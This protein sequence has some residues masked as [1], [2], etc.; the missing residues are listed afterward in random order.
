MER[1][2]KPGEVWEDATLIPKTPAL[3]DARVREPD[4]VPAEAPEVVEEKV[5]AEA[6][7]NNLMDQNT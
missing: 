5:A 4:K 3:E 2:R 6:A 7:V 1:V